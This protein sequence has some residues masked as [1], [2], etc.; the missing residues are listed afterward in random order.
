MTKITAEKRKEVADLI[1][2]G[3]NFTTICK[4]CKISRPSLNKIRKTLQESGNESETLQ[5]ETETL[6]ESV[7]SESESVN[8]ET[9]SVSET[10]TFTKEIECSDDQAFPANQHCASAQQAL[11]KG[12]PHVGRH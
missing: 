9:E 7:N 2:N 6:Q 8:S 1:E 3:E 10:E 5:S 12:A 11:F 4:K